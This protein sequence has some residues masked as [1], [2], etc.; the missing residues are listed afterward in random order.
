MSNACPK[1]VVPVTTY[2]L[3]PSAKP[4]NPLTGYEDFV[5]L[6]LTGS[7]AHLGTTAD[8]NYPTFRTAQLGAAT[9]AMSN[10]LERVLRRRKSDLK[11]LSPEKQAKASADPSFEVASVEDSDVRAAVCQTIDSYYIALPVHAYFSSEAVRGEVP[12]VLSCEGFAYRDGSG[13]NGLV[14]I[15]KKDFLLLH[16][17]SLP[18]GAP[19]PR[20]LTRQL[21]S[22]AEAL[23][24]GLVDDYNSFL[25][26]EVYDAY[27]LSH[28]EMVRVSLTGAQVY[29]A[30]SIE[31]AGVRVVVREEAD[32]SWGLT[33]RRGGLT[34]SAE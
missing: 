29:S 18:E 33:T 30:S 32:P 26:G 16:K 8:K 20:I 6:S 21:R 13:I 24:R 12:P 9:S 10:L 22:A 31:A 25:H 28:G 11:F 17:R 23:L 4:V 7:C 2:T 5:T 3:V 15:S 14:Y 1:S 34:D 27:H 19:M